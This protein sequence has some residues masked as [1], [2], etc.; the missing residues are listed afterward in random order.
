MQDPVYNKKIDAIVAN[1][2]DLADWF[3]VNS[4]KW[5]IWIKELLGYYSIKNI[6]S[7]LPKRCLEDSKTISYKSLNV[8]RGD[9]AQA[10]TSLRFLNVIDDKKWSSISQDLCAYCE[11]DVRAMIAVE[12]FGIELI[13]NSKN[14]SN[15][16]DIHLDIFSLLASSLKKPK[17]T[18]LQNF[19]NKLSKLS[20]LDFK[21]IILQIESELGVM[22]TKLKEWSSLIK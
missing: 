15:N 1:L 11:N 2:Y 3:N 5:F 9:K 16:F 19:L 20:K 18:L 12:K 14:K 6:L 7:L 10:L 17:E 4:S 8:Q 22:E 13:E 21:N